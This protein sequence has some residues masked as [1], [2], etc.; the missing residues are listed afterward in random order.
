MKKAVLLLLAIA[1]LGCTKEETKGNVVSFLT[2]EMEANFKQTQ[3]QNDVRELFYFDDDGNEIGIEVVEI[4]GI[5]FKGEVITGTRAPHAH[6]QHNQCPVPSG[7]HIWGQQQVSCQHY[8]Y[9][10]MAGLIWLKTCHRNN[11]NCQ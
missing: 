7:H 9:N 11:Q 6:Q 2:S 8:V 10:Q 1:L 4:D 5:L 3:V